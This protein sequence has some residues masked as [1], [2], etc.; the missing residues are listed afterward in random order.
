MR[1][2]PEELQ[3]KRKERQEKELE[4]C[5][6]RCKLYLF[7]SLCIFFCIWFII[8]ICVSIIHFN[9]YD[10]D[11]DYYDEINLDSLSSSSSSSF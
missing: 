11:N 8:F 7:I 3:Q 2:S 6:N 1:I 9:E 4:E 5:C 10:N